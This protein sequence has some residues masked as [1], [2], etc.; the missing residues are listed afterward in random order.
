ML[1]TLLAFALTIMVIVAI[2]EYG[3]YLA[4]RLFGVRVL[5]FSIGF[6]PQLAKWKSKTGTKFVISAIP[7]G[8]Y[9]R[10][11]DKRDTEILPGQEGE[12]FSHKPAW[13]RVIV[14]ATGPVAN[15][16]LAIFLYWVIFLGGQL[17]VPPVLGKVAEESPAAVAGLQENDEIVALDGKQVLTWQQVNMELI[18]HV[19]SVKPLAVT[20]KDAE[21]RERQVSLDLAS[22]SQDPEAPVFEVLGITPR[23][24]APILGQVIA[25]GAADKAGLQEND[26]IITA[27]GN[28]VNSWSDWV[29][30]VQNSP[31][32]P[33]ALEVKRGQQL[34]QLELTPQPK[35]MD[36]E[37]IGLA[38]VQL[39]GLRQLDYGFFES[40]GAALTRTS[41]QITMILGSFKKMILGQLSVKT[42][43]GPITIAQAAGETAAIGLDSFLL[44]LA[45]FS[46]SLGVINLLPVP[47]L[48]GGWIMF[49]LIEMVRRKPLSD[50]F[51]MTAQKMG[52]AL[53]L[54]LMSLAIFNDLVRQFS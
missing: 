35:E 19:G 3:H 23:P 8:G 12:E 18:R 32:K 15:F 31:E 43:G 48:D 50:D 34:Q 38:G 54:A 25:G 5:V 33:I 20:V 14:Y 45:F 46:I 21:Q 16:I 4:M 37:R 10:P 17:G 2:H 9:V 29:A 7:L 36:G 27:N 47:M 49:G 51:L 39:G 41:D 24:L 6:G 13:Q 26:Q 40:M 28:P 53:V 11:L 44:F 42:L 1:T 52:F 30:V 22:W